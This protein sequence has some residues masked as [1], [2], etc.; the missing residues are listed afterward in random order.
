MA[1]PTITDFE[2]MAALAYAR[3]PPEFLELTG[4]V[5]IEIEDFP[6]DEIVEEMQLGSE[7]DLLG[8][9]RG[10][11]MTEAKA[12][13]E[14]GQM[15]NHIT[16]YRRPILDYWCEHEDTLGDIITHVLIHEIGHHFGLSD[17]DMER[18]EASVG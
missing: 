7:F 9:F 2:V 3:L 12:A 5:L 4:N 15:P 17:D 18:I 6:E 13:P 1:A 16:L 8:L 10:I 14:T 11:G